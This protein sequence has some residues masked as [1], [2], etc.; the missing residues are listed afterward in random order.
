MSSIEQLITPPK[1]YANI[2]EHLRSQM[3]WGTLDSNDLSDLK[4]HKVVIS[5]FTTAYH[6]SINVKRVIKY[7]SNTSGIILPDGVD[8]KDKEVVESY[9][10]SLEETLEPGANHPIFNFTAFRSDLVE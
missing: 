9:H 5:A 4:I 7:S 8:A 2:V 3:N 1:I 10:G 6:F